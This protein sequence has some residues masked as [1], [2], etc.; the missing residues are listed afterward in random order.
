MNYSTIIIA[1]LLITYCMLYSN[2]CGYAALY[3]NYS[4]KKQL[5]INYS[6]IVSSRVLEVQDCTHQLIQFCCYSV[7]ISHSI[8]DGTVRSRAAYPQG[9]HI[10]NFLLPQCSCMSTQHAVHH[11]CTAKP[12]NRALR[13]ISAV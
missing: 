12:V 7:F 2:S 4:E 1:R 8:I 9:R 6:V 13:K 3:Y 11:G 10:Q 5:Q